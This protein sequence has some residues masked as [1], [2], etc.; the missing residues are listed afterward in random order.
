MES[1]S[2]PGNGAS[3]KHSSLGFRLLLVLFY[4]NCGKFSC[5]RSLT[6]HALKARGEVGEGGVGVVV[7]VIR[8]EQEH[9]ENNSVAMVE[10]VIIPSPSTKYHRPHPT[11]ISPS[12]NGM[13]SV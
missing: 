4:T 11:L 6:K 12:P 7:G 13:G 2:D 5:R 3:N 10:T 1:K 8:L 9:Y